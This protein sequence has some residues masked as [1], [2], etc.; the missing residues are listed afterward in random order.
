MKV[1]P[2]III[3]KEGNWSHFEGGMVVCAKQAV[4]II[5]GR[6]FLLGFAHIPGLKK[7]VTKTGNIR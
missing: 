3:G 7:I 4:Q 2:N 1:K 6:V 5:S